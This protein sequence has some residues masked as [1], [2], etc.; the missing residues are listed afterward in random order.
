MKPGIAHRTLGWTVDLMRTLALGV[1]VALAM[2]G[3]PTGVIAVREI[4][5]PRLLDRAVTVAPEGF[6]LARLEQTARAYLRENSA[7][8]YILR[9]TLAPDRLILARTLGKGPPDANFPSLLEAIKR[10]GLPAG[11]VAQVLSIG[12][13]SVLVYR[14]ASGFAEKYLTGTRAP[15]L[16]RVGGIKFRLLHFRI[17]EMRQEPATAAA[18]LYVASFF[19]TVSGEVSVSACAAATRQLAKLFAMP[20]S[21]ASCRTIPWFVEDPGFPD[22]FPF[23]SKISVPSKEEYFLLPSVGCSENPKSGLRCSGQNFVP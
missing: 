15:R 18:P 11:P 20:Y 23:V 13:A 8:R 3:Q 9:L 19:L 14:D 16:L 12:A 22:V 1:V 6:S 2:L 10:V 5:T 4:K 7:D 17:Q 21:T